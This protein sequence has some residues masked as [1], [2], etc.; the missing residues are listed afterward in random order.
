HT[1]TVVVDYHGGAS[2]G[3]ITNCAH[4][5]GSGQTQ[6]LTSGG[7]TATFQNVPAVDLTACDT[8][9]IGPHVC[10]PGAP[11]CGWINGDM[12]S[13][14][15]EDWGANNFT[16]PAPETLLAH[17][18]AV[19]PLGGVEVGINGAAGFSI[20]FLSAAAV[21]DYLP[22]SGAPGTFNIDL[23]DPTS[24]N[25]GLF[26][27]AVLAMRLDIDFSDAGFLPNTSGLEFGDL[28]LC[29]LTQTSL[30][31]MNIRSLMSFMNTAL[32]SGSTGGFTDDELTNLALNVTRAF[33]GG[34][35]STFAQEHLF[36][37]S[38]P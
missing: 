33:T 37:G 28:R 12:L 22:A 13:Y 16:D 20:L 35:P 10:T 31:G 17:F 30:N 14:G 3:T 36:S 9:V 5:T 23:V 18:D 8:R 34:V 7:D 6:T 38:C 11:G 29:N 21:L 32:G 26:G 24:T 1:G 15:Q 25:S 2:G 19:Y 27:G 4:L